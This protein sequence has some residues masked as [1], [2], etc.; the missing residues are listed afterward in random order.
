MVDR[1]SLQAAAADP[2]ATLGDLLS[3]RPPPAF[4]LPDESCRIAAERLVSSGLERLPVVSDVTSLRLVGIVS[5][6]D[7]LKPMRT[8][9]EEEMLR[10]RLLQIGGPG[11]SGTA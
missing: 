11:S 10:E 4:A 6:S 3:R 5:R 7:L 9:Y 8:R 1:E 2:A